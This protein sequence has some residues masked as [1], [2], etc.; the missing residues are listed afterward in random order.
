[1]SMIVMAKASSLVLFVGLAMDR[2][3]QFSIVLLFLSMEIQFTESCMIMD[4]MLN[5]IQ[6]VNFKKL[7][8][9][10]VSKL[11]KMTTFNY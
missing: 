2:M 1:M 3:E 9:I 4:V 10:I 5:C 6:F 8:N 7:V 11:K